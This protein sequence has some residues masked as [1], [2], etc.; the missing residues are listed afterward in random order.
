M[1]HF[2]SY[3]VTL[4][5]VEWHEIEFSCGP[6][7]LGSAVFNDA[8]IEHYGCSIST[9]SSITFEQP[10][11]FLSSFFVFL[12]SVYKETDNLSDKESFGSLTVRAQQFKLAPLK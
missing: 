9:T 1:S 5:P 6:G 2:W 12:F 7:I 10:H 3:L 11:P 4:W 8:N